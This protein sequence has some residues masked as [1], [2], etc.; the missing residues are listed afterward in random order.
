MLRAILFGLFLLLFWGTDLR[1]D[2]TPAPTGHIAKVLPFLMN[3]KGQVAPSP[4]LFDRDAYQAYLLEHTNEVS[5]IR[6]DVSWNAHHASG[7]KLKLRLDLK[8]VGAGGLPTQTVLEQTVTP[9]FFH[10]WISL[11]LAGPDYKKFGALAAWHATLWN[12]GQLIGEQQS[13]LWSL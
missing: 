3:K 6:F 1:A 10:H 2:S 4:S 7:M 8:G 9:K 12:G 5:G 11:T 13:F